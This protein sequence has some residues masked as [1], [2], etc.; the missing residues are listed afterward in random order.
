[1]TIVWDPDGT[2]Y[3]L[4]KGYSLFLD[5][6]RELSTDKLGKVIFDPNTDK[7][8]AEDGVTVTYTARGGKKF[9]TAVD[10]PIKD[11]RVVD[12]LKTAGIDLTEGAPNVAPAPS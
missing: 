11:K 6:K 7:A 9:P 4:G 3:G 5:G 2:A 8:Q 10:T 1:M 12:Y